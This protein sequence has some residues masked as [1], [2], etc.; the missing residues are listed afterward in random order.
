MNYFE[1]L[2]PPAPCAVKGRQ[3]GLLG[4]VLQRRLEVLARNKTQFIFELA[5]N[6]YLKMLMY[7]H[8]G[9]PVLT[10]H[11]D[12]IGASKK[13][14]YEFYTS[15]WYKDDPVES[16]TMRKEKGNRKF[17]WYKVFTD[18]FI[19]ALLAEEKEIITFLADYTESWFVPESL[20]MPVD[21]AWGWIYISVAASFRTKPLDGQAEM[22][23]LIR[24]SRKPAPKLLFK[25]WE[26][27]REHNQ[28]DFEKHLRDSVLMHEKKLPEELCNDDLIA[29]PQSVVLA[30]ARRLGLSLPIFE[31][32]VMARLLTS[33]SVGIK[34]S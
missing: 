11:R 8:F 33:E 9:E 5:H 15:P 17:G 30:A 7:H 10:D 20:A 24:K 32:R 25:A 28:L 18:T 6:C 13:L 4:D 26:A 27:A 1:I 23:E 34:P 29:F 14:I 3:T 12:I 16:E 31:P 22:E 21:P 19:M 2:S